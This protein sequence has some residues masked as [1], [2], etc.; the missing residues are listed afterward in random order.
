VVSL[1]S[2]A[3]GGSES[4][5]NQGTLLDSVE[6]ED[7]DADPFAALSRKEMVS[8]TRDVLQ[9]LSPKEMTILRL[10]FGLT[11]D[12]T[13]HVRFPITESELA[14]VKAGVGIR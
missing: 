11:E 1:S 8:L 9:S 2:P 4:D 12:P 5:P 13:D 6:S 14:G 10:R 7:P 3:Y